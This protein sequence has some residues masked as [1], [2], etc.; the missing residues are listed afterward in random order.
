VPH[1]EPAAPPHAAR[2]ARN[3]AVQPVRTRG[4]VRCHIAQQCL[5]LATK[6]LVRA[7]V[8]Q[9]VGETLSQ[10]IAVFGDG[11]ATRW[12]ILRLTSTP[13]RHL[14]LRTFLYTELN[15]TG[16]SSQHGHGDVAFRTNDA[17]S[18]NCKKSADSC[19]M[20]SVMNCTFHQFLLG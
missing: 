8:R 16:A 4:L 2:S 9:L 5:E 18:I 13:A 19:I 6:T 10:V 3:T 11:T 7:W 1:L 20:K 14:K 12:T 17:E 15:M